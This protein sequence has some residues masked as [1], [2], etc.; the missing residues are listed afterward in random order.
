VKKEENN[1][2]EDS[3]PGTSVGE[4]SDWRCQLGRCIVSHPFTGTP[5]NKGSTLFTVPIL[6][7]A[8]ITSI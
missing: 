6:Y 2:E 4:V 7:Y 3:Q 5:T 1:I 8:G